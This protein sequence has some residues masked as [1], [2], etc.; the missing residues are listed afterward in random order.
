MS[1][2][3][4]VE[5]LNVAYKVGDQLFENE[6]PAKNYRNGM[7]FKAMVADAFSGSLNDDEQQVV[8]WLLL[9]RMTQLKYVIKKKREEL[10]KQIEEAKAK[11]NAKSK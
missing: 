5:K 10:M 1:K 7:T 6:L 8:G 11:K 9:N 4:K 3:L 2:K